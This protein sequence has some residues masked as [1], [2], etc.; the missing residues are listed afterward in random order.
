M[1]YFDSIN[2]NEK[3]CENINNDDFD[4]YKIDH[5]LKGKSDFETSARNPPKRFLNAAD[6]A[7]ADFSMLRCTATDRIPII[8][9]LGLLGDS[10]NL[11]NQL[12]KHDTLS[13]E[14]FSFQ[15]TFLVIQLQNIKI[16]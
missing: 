1:N 15:R 4:A 8:G 16:C 6:D 12:N 10:E 7:A 3:L 11:K 2:L 13:N 5:F 14:K 9:F